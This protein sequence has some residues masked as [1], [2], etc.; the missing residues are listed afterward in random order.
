[1]ITSWMGSPVFELEL[2]MV[3]DYFY[4]PGLNKPSIE[5]KGAVIWFDRISGMIE[6]APILHDGTLLNKV[7]CIQT[8]KV[9]GQDVLSQLGATD[10]D[11]LQEWIDARN[12]RTKHERSEAEQA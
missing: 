2:G 5:Q 3:I 12:G 8:H 9:I 1:M 10:R 11:L 4:C 6:T 7:H